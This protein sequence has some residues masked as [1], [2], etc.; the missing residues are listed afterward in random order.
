MKIVALRVPE[1]I[2]KRMKEVPEDWSD[3]LRKAIEDRINMED[4]KRLLTEVKALLKN[5]PKA[6]KGTA[7]K[8]IRE[9]RNRG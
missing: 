7:A 3:Y 6:P 5:V 2:K 4:R 9:M 8:I 1:D